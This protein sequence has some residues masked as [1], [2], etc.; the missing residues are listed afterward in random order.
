MSFPPIVIVTSVVDFVTDWI[1]VAST[2]DVFAPEH[3][4]KVSDVPA[5][6]CVYR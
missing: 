2:S 1:W 5:C 3:A 4:T 6:L